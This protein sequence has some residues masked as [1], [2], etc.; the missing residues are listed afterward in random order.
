MIVAGNQHKQSNQPAKQEHDTKKMVSFLLIIVIIISY[1]K[2]ELLLKLIPDKYLRY[3][4]TFQKRALIKD[5]KYSLLTFFALLDSIAF[6]N[7]LN[8][9]GLV[10]VVFFGFLF[11]KVG[12]PCIKEMKQIFSVIRQDMKQAEKRKVETESEKY[13]KNDYIELTRNDYSSDDTYYYD[14]NKQSNKKKRR[15]K[16]NDP[17]SY[18]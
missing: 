5:L 7:S 18:F 3:A 13:K 2:P 6:L 12:I 14:K 4:T 10:L 15:N 1:G 9:L 8:F 11:Y 16:D 17:I